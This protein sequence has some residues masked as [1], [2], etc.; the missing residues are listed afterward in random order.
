MLE[1]LAHQL[2]VD[3]DHNLLEAALKCLYQFLALGGK[4]DKENLVLKT[5]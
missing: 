1:I 5:V 4:I 2:Q 3:E